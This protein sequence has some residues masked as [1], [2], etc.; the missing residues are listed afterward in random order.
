L[1][2]KPH[3][4]PFLLVSMM[5]PSAS[6]AETAAPT[7][8]PVY[9][10]AAGAVV[11]GLSGLVAGTQPPLTNYSRS[12][13]RITQFRA[14]AAKPVTIEP[15]NYDVLCST[16]GAYASM[17]AKSAYINSIIGTLDKFATPPKISTIGDAFMSL[18]K[19]YQSTYRLANYR[20]IRRQT[21]KINVGPISTPGR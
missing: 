2:S 10:P 6:R 12:S 3:A 17:A 16:R 8:T 19:N 18:F 11:S 1:I 20:P 9:T 5:L 13:S 4:L 14:D 15:K 7:P 21:Y